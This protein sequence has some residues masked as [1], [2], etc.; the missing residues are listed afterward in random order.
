MDDTMKKDLTYFFPAFIAWISLTLIATFWNIQSP[1]Y[2]FNFPMVVVGVSIFI[3]GLLKRARL[4]EL[5]ARGY[6]M[7]CQDEST[8][9]AEIPTTEHSISD[10]IK[11]IKTI[12]NTHTFYSNTDLDVRGK[13][14]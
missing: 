14:I 12:M 6:V 7:S 3:V 11:T 4:K 13:R 5:E 9:C 1:F 8:I 10:D 2:S